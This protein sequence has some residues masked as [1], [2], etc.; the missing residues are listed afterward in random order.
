MNTPGNGRSRKAARLK[1]AVQFFYD[2][3]GY[4]YKVNEET[5]EQ[6]HKRYAKALA[7]AEEAA[8]Q[9][10]YSFEWIN[11]D[12]CI[13]CDCQNADCACCNRTTHDCYSCTMRD[14]NGEV[15]AS[16]GSICE[17]TV[18]YRRVVQAELATEVF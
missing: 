14:E 17:P 15:K 1:N 12:E 3:A 8:H 4:S 6:G 11:G 7:K 2:F 16:L 10:F 5:P 9:A 13:G 18:E